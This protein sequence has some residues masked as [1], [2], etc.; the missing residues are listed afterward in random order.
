[1]THSKFDEEEEQYQFRH[2][3]DKSFHLRA[4]KG[5]GN[6]GTLYKGPFH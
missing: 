2:I 3:D 1:M 4:W 6:K 5:I